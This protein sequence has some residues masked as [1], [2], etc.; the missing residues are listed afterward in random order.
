M[1]IDRKTVIGSR[2]IKVIAA[3]NATGSRIRPAPREPRSPSAR[4]SRIPVARQ[5]VTKIAKLTPK[6]FFQKRKSNDHPRN[7]TMIQKRLGLVFIQGL[8]EVF[9][10]LVLF[11]LR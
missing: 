1:E 8:H 4:R 11:G 2:R 9:Q 3:R 6:G 10:S 7:S 5:R